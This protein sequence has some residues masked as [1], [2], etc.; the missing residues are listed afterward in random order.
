MHIKS[1]K[2]ILT[3]SLCYANQLTVVKINLKVGILMKTNEKIR[4]LRHEHDWSQKEM[5]EKLQMSVN[6]YSKI[7]RGE[8]R[9]S[10]DR[11]Q[12]IAETL[13]VQL[14]ELLPSNDGNI[15]FMINEGDNYHGS[16][17]NS[18]DVSVEL[19]KLK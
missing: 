17:Y 8:S 7:E 5:A 16:F 15:V 12:Q 10:V 6:G 13:G 11:L 19:E 1:S 18:G 9:P 3:I 4:L 2:E 14:N